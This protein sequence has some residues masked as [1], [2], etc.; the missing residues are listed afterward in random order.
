MTLNNVLFATCTTAA[1]GAISRSTV[2]DHRFSDNT[3]EHAL[4][5]LPDSQSNIGSFLTTIWR[6]KVVEVHKIK[7]EDCAELINTNSELRFH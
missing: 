2:S 5:V 1:G 4:Y 7:I 3:R 6:P